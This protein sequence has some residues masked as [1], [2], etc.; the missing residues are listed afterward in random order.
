MA[1]QI[2]ACVVYRAQ[3]VIVISLLQI[4]F[5]ILIGDTAAFAV[6]KILTDIAQHFRQIL[7]ILRLASNTLIEPSRSLEAIR[8]DQNIPMLTV[9]IISLNGMIDH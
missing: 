8:K 5:N 6:L 7:K 9:Q 4:S 1:L 2:E 3:Q